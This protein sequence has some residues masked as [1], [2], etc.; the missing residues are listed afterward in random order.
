VEIPGKMQLRTG[1]ALCLGPGGGVVSGWSS[2]FSFQFSVVS[3][4]WSVVSGQWSVVS[5]QW[6]V[7]SFQCP[8]SSPLG[9]RGSCRAVSGNRRV[10][11]WCLGGIVSPRNDTEYTEKPRGNGRAVDGSQRVEF[12]FQCPRSSPWE[13]EAPAEPRVATV[14]LLW[15]CVGG[16]IS[17]RNTRNI[18]KNPGATGEPLT[19][20]SGWSLVFSA[21][22]VPLG[23]ARLLPSRGWQPWGCCGGV[24]V[25]LFHHGRT[26]NTRK[27]NGATDEPLAEAS[28]WSSVFS[29]CEVPPWEGEAPAEPWVA[30]EGC[31]CGVWV[32]LFHHGRTRN[33]RKNP[34]ATGE[35]LAEASGWSSVFSAR[36]VPPWEGEAPAEP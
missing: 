17:P 31:C 16:F 23:R 33:T 4:Q 8:R 22:E 14:G 3:G 18:R 35:P 20:A 13:G 34:G 29:A 11:L 25:D 36:E 2:V 12:S 1:A 6:S 27:N 15:W 9:G 7:F 28:G 10:L 30:T 19:E 24:W 21:C 26:R 5:G 32:D